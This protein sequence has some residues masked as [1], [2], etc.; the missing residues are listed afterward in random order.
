MSGLFVSLSLDE[1]GTVK[2]RMEDQ[3]FKVARSQSFMSLMYMAF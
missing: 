2:C 3:P 1:Q